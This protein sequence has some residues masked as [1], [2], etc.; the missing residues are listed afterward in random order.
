MDGNFFLRWEYKLVKLVLGVDKDHHGC[1][2]VMMMTIIVMLNVRQP[3]LFMCQPEDDWFMKSH[4]DH[5][6][7]INIRLNLL[8]E[9]SVRIS[10]TIIVHSAFWLAVELWYLRDSQMP[11]G[12]KIPK[13]LKK[14]YLSH[15][16][17]TRCA[18]HK[19]YL[20]CSIALIHGQAHGG[21]DDTPTSHHIAFMI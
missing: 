12:K 16:K 4:H 1:L 19:R 18:S 17:I 13:N 6:L 15:F 11:I 8:V 2:I 7:Y 5:G 10:F 9:E 14:N 20:S 21:T 3:L